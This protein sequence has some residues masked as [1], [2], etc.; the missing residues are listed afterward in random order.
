MTFNSP[1]RNMKRSAIALGLFI[2]SLMAVGCASPATQPQTVT[3][4]VTPS[5][6]ATTAAA[7]AP[8]ITTEAAVVVTPPPTTAPTT[9]P[10]PA[11]VA[12]S[13]IM[14]DV[15]C[16]NLQVAQDMIQAAGVFFSR[17]SDASGKERSQLVDSNW[18][19]VSQ[20]PTAGSLVGEAEAVLAAVKIGEPGDCS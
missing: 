2:I 13:A 9:E 7:V 11:P 15:T 4:E 19:V 14:P 5:I 20:T 3:V 6:I 12:V 8:V 18:T 10:A 17:S 1:G 16:M